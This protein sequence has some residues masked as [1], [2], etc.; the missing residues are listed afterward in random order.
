VMVAELPSRRDQFVRDLNR[1]PG[2]RC[3][4]PEGAFYT[5]VNV[6]DTGTSAEEICRIMLEDAGVAAIP[7]AAFGV[8]GKAFVRFSFAS[9]T[10][11]L[12]E[13]VERILSV[14]SAWQGTLVRS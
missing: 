7:G 5:W 4:A 13:A 2:L 3:T 1:V 9:S 11:T 10:A 14:S 8:S 6:S 12:Q